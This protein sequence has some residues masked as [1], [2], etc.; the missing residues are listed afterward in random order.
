[1]QKR[2]K[3][4]NIGTNINH[5]LNHIININTYRTHT[6][7]TDIIHLY[8]VSVNLCYS[9]RTGPV[10]HLHDVP[11]YH[12]D[13]SMYI[14]VHINFSTHCCACFSPHGA[15]LNS[16]ILNKASRGPKYCREFVLDVHSNVHTSIKT[17]PR[18]ITLALKRSGPNQMVD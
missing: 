2:R 6:V 18:N 13:G 8:T 5:I 3:I 11:Q 17:I 12:F 9:I 15:L 7:C 10:Q 16:I 14:T 4:Y 1:M